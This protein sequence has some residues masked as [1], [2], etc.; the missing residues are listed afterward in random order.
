M[1]PGVSFNGEGE[2]GGIITMGEIKP[3]VSMVWTKRN[4]TTK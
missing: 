1:Q 3:I 2:G 4:N